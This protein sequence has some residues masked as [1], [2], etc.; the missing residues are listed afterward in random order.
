MGVTENVALYIDKMSV[1]LSD[2]SRKSG[3]GY[4]ALYASLKDSGRKRE[5]RAEELLRICKVLKVDPMSFS[6]WE[7]KNEAD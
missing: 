2:L 3:I 1:N 4:P 7:K 5:L 6:E